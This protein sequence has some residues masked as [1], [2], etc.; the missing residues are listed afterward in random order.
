MSCIAHQATREQAHDQ[1]PTMHGGAVCQLDRR[2]QAEYLGTESG[3]G[4]QGV[5][6]GGRG[7]ALPDLR[8]QGDI[9]MPDM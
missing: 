4:V 1:L 7:Q 9:R 8:I 2:L 5:D 3:G 6:G